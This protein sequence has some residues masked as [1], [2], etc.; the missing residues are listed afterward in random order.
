[1][2]NRPL[3]ILALLGALCLAGTFWWVS[4]SGVSGGPP[5]LLISIDT[6]RAD[7]LGVL[8]RR[9]ADGSSPTPVLDRLA[10]SC[11]G[12]KEALTVTPLTLPAHTSL[13]SGLYPD[14]H[15]VRENDSFRVP[16]RD[17]RSYVLLQERLRESGYQ[18]AGFVS[19][20]PLERQYG[21]SAGFEVW[22]QPSRGDQLTGVLSF[23]ERSAEDTTE[24]VR[25][26]LSK[27]DSSRPTFLLVHYF[28]PHDPYV[29]PVEHPG[30]PHTREG[31][32]LSE[33]MSVDRQIGRLLEAWPYDLEDSV[34]IVLSDHGEGLGEHGEETHGHLLHQATLR[35][36][37]LFKVPVGGYAPRVEGPISLVDV[38]PTV[39][40]LAKISYDSS[41]MDGRNL[42][43]D[44]SPNLQVWA[45]TL[46]P[47]Y[48]FQYAHQQ[49]LFDADRK[50][51]A[52][53][54][55]ESLF[56]YVGDPAELNDLAPRE[57][58]RLK[59][60]REQLRYFRGTRSSG[61][62]MDLEVEVNA[63][64]PYMGGRPLHFPIEPGEEA[65]R[66]LRDIQDR[67][68]V[69]Q[70][71]DRARSYL[72]KRPPEPWSA[73]PLLMEF[74]DEFG[75]NPALLFWTARAL[76]H[77]GRSETMSQGTREAK[78]VEALEYYGR[79]ARTFGDHRSSEARLRVHMD[80]FDVS[81]DRRHLEDLKREATEMISVGT[82]RPLVRALRSR[83]YE[84][85]GDLES[86]L[87]D[88]EAA[89]ELDREDPRFFRDIRR[90]KGLLGL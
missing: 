35:V 78:L 84:A 47:Y 1:M 5:I 20:Q 48:Q 24:A 37:F 82:D 74:E 62:A 15:G 10:A 4:R 41:F 9:L 30:L 89:A 51:V 13:L 52:G 2:R 32:Y 79:H 25:T 54:S 12:P 71:L 57:G 6:C 21:L 29:R 31:D 81:L 16:P 18:T 76:Q 27:V 28:D 50:Y 70:A 67:L 86:A 85:L 66:G 23:R 77:W 88:M 59:R 38:Y 46:Y 68:E 26:W 45:E 90:L 22:S 19:G 55:L 14:R 8:G 72:A 34:V 7:A 53:S 58:E 43:G 33:I 44:V 11:M 69:V 36:P 40:G 87:S 39:C 80:L 75:T 63:A 61:A 83:A 3:L 17:E 60:M 65:N 73:L 49:A 56:A 42:L 64:V